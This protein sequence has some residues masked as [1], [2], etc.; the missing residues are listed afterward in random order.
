MHWP[1]GRIIGVSC[2]RR[3]APLR[4]REPP[5]RF[6]GQLSRPGVVFGAAPLELSSK[7]FGVVPPRFSKSKK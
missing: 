4:A 1:A 6:G 7:T 3:A 2:Q 5:L